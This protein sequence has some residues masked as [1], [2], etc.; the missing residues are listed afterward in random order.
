VEIFFLINL[1][2]FFAS[3]TK[4]STQEEGKGR[5]LNNLKT[6]IIYNQNYKNFNFCK[7]WIGIVP[8]FKLFFKSNGSI[9]N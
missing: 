6:W 4:I 8:F 3:P 9:S 7:P 1:F 5:F 2:V